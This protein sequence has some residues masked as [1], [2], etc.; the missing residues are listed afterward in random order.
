MKIVAFSNAFTR[1]FSGGDRIFVELAKRW[2]KMG[3]DICLVTCEDA[4]ETYRKYGLDGIDWIV[5]SSRRNWPVYLAYLLRMFESIV[6]AYRKVDFE[7]SVIYSASDFWPDSIPAW[8]FKMR[9]RSVRWLAGFY[10]FPPFPF[11][12]PS[13]YKG[14]RRLRSL[15]YYSSQVP[16]YGLVRRFADMIWVTNELDR[17]RFIDG[18]KVTSDRVV[19]IKGGVDAKTPL[20]IPEPKTKKFDAIFIGRLVPEKGILELIDVWKYVCA[21]K[22]DAMLAILGSGPLYDGVQNKI[23]QNDLSRNVKVF[24]F[25]DGME[26]YKIIRES[27]VVVHPSIMDSGGMAA[28]EAMVC[29]LPGVSFDLESLK[30][31]YPKGMFKVP[32]YDLKI[33][34]D[35]ILKLLEDESFYQ[36]LSEEASNFAKNWDWDKVARDALNKIQVIIY[37]RETKLELVRNG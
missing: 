2:S 20:L 9:F 12:R 37:Q 17:W 22:E 10:F 1:G 11:S 14:L 34:A 19:A 27:K 25:I 31:Y 33:F 32:C 3:C 30:T 16:V 23:R 13:P 26:K 28:C 6:L 15:F 21:K 29:G 18:K 24:G 4:C 35:T 36:C 5:V 7:G 8:L